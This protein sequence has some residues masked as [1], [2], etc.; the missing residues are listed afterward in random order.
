M[1]TT[2]KNDNIR[3]EKDENGKLFSSDVINRVNFR[4]S[5]HLNF[6]E[7]DYEVIKDNSNFSNITL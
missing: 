7:R 6:I 1:G 5:R 2:L 3:V 4:I